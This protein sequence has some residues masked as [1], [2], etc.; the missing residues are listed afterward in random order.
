MLSEI[1]LHLITIVVDEASGKV[2]D[3]PLRRILIELVNIIRE[4]GVLGELT[5]QDVIG[6]L[7]VR[8]SPVCSV[9]GGSAVELM[10]SC[11]RPRLPLVE[12][13]L[14][15]DHLTAVEVDR[16]AGAIKLL[17]EH[18]EVKAVAIVPRQITSLDESCH[19]LGDLGEGGRARHILI[20]DT[21]DCG[22]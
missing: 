19:T 20:A 16:Y 4:V 11:E 2:H 13:H 1:E 22:R 5:T 8:Q 6:R 17:A 12:D 3:P 10:R 9:E 18:R 7:G 14:H 21:V 15:I